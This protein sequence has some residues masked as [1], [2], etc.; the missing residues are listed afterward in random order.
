MGNILTLVIS[1]MMS[2]SFLTA[3]DLPTTTASAD[4]PKGITAN[5][6]LSDFNKD[7]QS[8][9]QP[10]IIRINE[11]FLREF[12][13]TNPKS[14][15]ILATSFNVWARRDFSGKAK[16]GL[17]PEDVIADLFN[18][19]RRK[20]IS[21]FLSCYTEASASDIMKGFKLNEAKFWSRWDGVKE[22]KPAF[23]VITAGGNYVTF[24]TIDG[25]GNGKMLVPLQLCF[26]KDVTKISYKNSE[27]EMVLS[28]MSAYSF[29]PQALNFFD[30]PPSEPTISK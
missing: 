24:C 12:G 13:I 6:K 2:V 18:A 16:D 10:T 11:S 28:L 27:G 7:T 4:S 15:G 5:I 21:G 25:K 14:V 22:I 19:I 8:L 3:A 29:G 26:E 30:A 20:D 1:V 9:F 23:S 17:K